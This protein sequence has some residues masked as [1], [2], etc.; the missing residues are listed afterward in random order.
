MN[1]FRNSIESIVQAPNGEG[2]R[3]A[4]ALLFLFSSA[5]GGVQRLRRNVYSRRWLAS[6]RLPCKVVSVGN[7]EVG[8][9][10]KTPMTAYLAEVFQQM[11]RRVAVISRGYKGTG[12]GDRHIVSDGKRL[13]MGTRQSGDEA[14]LLAG[15]LRSVPVL[16]GRDRYQVGM[17]A[18][19]QFQPDIV[20]LDDGF[21]HLRLRRDLDLVLLDNDRPF[22]NGHLLP[23]GSLREPVDALIAADGIV[24][25]RSGR[26]CR[27]GAELADFLPPETPVFHSIHKPFLAAAPGGGLDGE[28]RRLPLPVYHDFDRLRNARLA[29]FSGIARNDAF[30]RTLVEKGAKV[31]AFH[32]FGDHHC[33]S[34]REIERITSEARQ[35]GADLLATTEKDLVRLPPAFPWPL[36][37]VVVGIR[38]DFGDQDAAFRNFLRSRLGF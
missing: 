7:L 10:G 35:A 13:L 12:A 30:R 32:A 34:R 16:I 18:V 3:L 22:G 31:V 38:I 19:G 27:P 6:S 4:R 5:Y 23:R 36:E 21:Q 15:Q 11:G 14:Q 17:I 24:F 8:G 28:A 37:L 25:T 29:A 1:R 2:R 9:T 33:Y 20:I 26:N